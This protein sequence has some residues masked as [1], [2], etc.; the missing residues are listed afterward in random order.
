LLL[1]NAVGTSAVESLKPAVATE[2]D[3]QEDETSEA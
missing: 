2:A 3:K 1:K